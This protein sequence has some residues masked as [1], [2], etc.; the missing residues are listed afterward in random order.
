MSGDMYVFSHG[1]FYD[2]DEAAYEEMQ[3]GYIKDWRQKLKG[4]REIF[5]DV[6]LSS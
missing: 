4:R 5:I 1:S 6:V 3:C 2:D